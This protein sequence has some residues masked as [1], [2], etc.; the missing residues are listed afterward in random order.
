M[1]LHLSNQEG[2]RSDSTIERTSQARMYRLV[3]D[4]HLASMPTIQHE[5]KRNFTKL[6]CKTFQALLA[7]QVPLLG[8]QLRK[9]N[10]LPVDRM[11]T[12][13]VEASAGSE[14]RGPGE[15]RQ[16]LDVN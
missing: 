12:D 8:Q 1:N 3:M 15:A 9:E 5:P 16:A 6:R 11:T 10:T 4:G 2:A 14:R 13:Q 7:L